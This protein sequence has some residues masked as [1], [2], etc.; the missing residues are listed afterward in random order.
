MKLSAG[1][2]RFLVREALLLEGD[3]IGPDAAKEALKKFPKGMHKLGIQNVDALKPLGT[4]TKGTAFDA[5]NKVLKVTPDAKE[6]QAAAV[7]VGKNVKNVV[8]FFGVYKLGDTGMFCIMQ[9]KLQ[10][11]S[12]EES[13]AFNKALV[14]TGLPL[15]IKRANGS[16]DKVRELTKQHILASV[17]K[18]FPDNLNSPE[19]QQFVKQTNEHW[20]S[21]VKKYG[22]KELFETLTKLGIDFHDYHA[23]N[24]MKR[25]DGTLVLID[26]GMSNIRG[27]GDIESITQGTGL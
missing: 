5:G 17:K 1:T 24:M 26:L 23:G 4:G 2:L 13:N 25:E 15:W 21:L 27:Q 18:K 8:N 3:E 20:S 11:I 12:P 6:A 22:L 14:A 7:L 16:W 10:P 19:A 9:E